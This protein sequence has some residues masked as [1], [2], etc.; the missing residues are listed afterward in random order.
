MDLSRVLE[1][2]DLEGDAPVLRA[3]GAQVRRAR[4]TAARAEI[5]VAVEAADLGED[6][7]SR[8][9]A[10]LYAVLAISGVTADESNAIYGRSSSL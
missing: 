4:E 9:S 10:C 2:G 1:V 8:A 3:L 7:R 6:L 5:A